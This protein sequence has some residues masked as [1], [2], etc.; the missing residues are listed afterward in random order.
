MFFALLEKQYKIYIM[1]RRLQFCVYVLYSLKDHKLY[2]GYS[3]NLKQRL[4]SHFQGESASTAPRRPFRLIYCEYF[5][6]MKDAKNREQ[7]LKTTAGKRGLKYIISNSLE[8]LSAN[9]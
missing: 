7:Y 8:D 9:S 2:V 1:I 5:Y 6:S 3:E 4:T